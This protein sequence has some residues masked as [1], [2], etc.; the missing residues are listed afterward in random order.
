VGEG[1][2]ASDD[3]STFSTAATDASTIFCT[4]LHSHQIQTI[5]KIPI[6][7]PKNRPSR[8]IPLIAADLITSEPGSIFKPVVPG[9][10]A[11]ATLIPILGLDPS[12]KLALCAAESVVLPPITNVVLEG[13]E[14]SSWDVVAVAALEL[15][16]G[17]D[18]EVED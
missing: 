14:W 8:T 17:E 1:D 7:I 3:I 6:N 13:L 12:W 4:S 11:V 10:A 16:E 9:P 18:E 5:P 15:G 2:F